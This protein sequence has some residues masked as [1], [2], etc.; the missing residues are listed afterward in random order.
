MFF[1]LDTP[2]TFTRMEVNFLVLDTLFFFIKII[3]KIGLNPSI[4]RGLIMIPARIMTKQVIL[5]L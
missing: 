2:Q 4:H 1:I 5:F 3:G